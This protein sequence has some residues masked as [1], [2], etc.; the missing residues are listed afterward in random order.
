VQPNL[1]TIQ[2]GTLEVTKT[3]SPV[4]IGRDGLGV[5]T[6]TGGTFISDVTMQVGI[7]NSTAGDGVI[8]FEGGVLQAGIS[9]AGV[10]STTSSTGI[11]LGSSTGTLGIIRVQNDGN[12]SSKII[13]NNLFVGYSQGAIGA[14]DYDY[15]NGNVKTINI[16]G[17]NSSPAAGGTQGQLALRNYAA[18]PTFGT[19]V[20][21]T[22]G[23]IGSVL[24]LT[25]DAAPTIIGGAV[26]NLALITYVDGVHGNSTDPTDFF[27]PN[28]TDLVN[29]SI[30]SATFG[31]NT[32]EWQLEYEGSVS[33]VGSEITSADISG[34]GGSS[35]GLKTRERG[36]WSFA[37]WTVRGETGTRIE[38]KQRGRCGQ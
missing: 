29:G 11:R 24:N 23:T 8:N 6:Q 20:D 36:K 22:G 3:S 17:G 21:G 34:T 18:T 38:L 30:I 27:S 4:I 15:Q 25:L 37:G 33:S 13:L 10:S 14:L 35:T 7:T 19:G 9:G 16:T 28:G 32:Y 2:N 31:G 12:A 26:Q 1:L 5:V